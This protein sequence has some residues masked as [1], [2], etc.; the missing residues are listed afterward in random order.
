MVFY[1]KAERLGGLE[2]NHQFEFGCDARL[3]IG[4]RRCEFIG[5]FDQATVA[6]P[7]GAQQTR[8]QSESHST[9]PYGEW[10]TNDYQQ[11]HW[12]AT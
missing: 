10:V 1:F 5:P 9:S 11:S 6:W 7:T 2:I 12:A 8:N 3:V 4:V